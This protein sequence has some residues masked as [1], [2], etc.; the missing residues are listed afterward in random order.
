MGAF[1]LGH[2]ALFAQAPCPIEII[3]GALWSMF[4]LKHMFFM[5]FD[6][7]TLGYKIPEKS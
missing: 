3:A 1:F 6:T 4:H 5:F 7:F 2:F